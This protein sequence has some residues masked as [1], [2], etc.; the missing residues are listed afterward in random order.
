MSTV[1][2]LRL[3]GDHFYVGRSM[4]PED[5][6][7]QHFT[8]SRSASV[9]TK[10]HKPIEIIEIF[11]NVDSFEEDK[12][13][14]IYMA[15]Y[16]IFSTRGGSYSTV[17]LDENT[18][19]FLLRE[20]RGAADLC[21]RCGSASH[22]VDQC[23]RKTEKPSTGKVEIPTIVCYICHEPGHVATKCPTRPPSTGK[24]KK[25]KVPT[26]YRCRAKGHYSNACPTLTK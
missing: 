10:L 16:G 13:V 4:V 2:V 20:I 19:N 21:F 6:I 11:S 3:Q 5:R 9:W 24:K 26:C 1:Y 23:R 14:K 22:R 7:L 15:K 25:K 17:T 18:T 12:I 8:G